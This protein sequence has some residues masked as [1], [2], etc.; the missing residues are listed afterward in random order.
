MRDDELPPSLKEAVDILRDGKEPRAEWTASVLDAAARQTFDTVAPTRWSFRPS[1]AIAASVAFIALG[2]AA[3][4]SLMSRRV[5][6]PAPVV[7]AAGA[8]QVRFTLVAPNAAKVTLVGDFNGWNASDLPMRR[9]ANGETWE[10]EVGLAPGRY[11]YSFVVDGRLA[12]D[13]AAAETAH[14]DFGAPNSVLLVKGS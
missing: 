2:S 8:R 5:E 12:R 7:A 9:S 10:V 3:T 6:R 1:M 14:D 4:Y 13:P 11:T